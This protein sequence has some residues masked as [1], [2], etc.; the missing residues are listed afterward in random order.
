MPEEN[1]IMIARPPPITQPGNSSSV[2][3]EDSNAAETLWE[4]GNFVIGRRAGRREQTNAFPCDRPYA[5]HARLDG[6]PSGIGIDMES[7]QIR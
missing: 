3:L 4:Y 7:S 1:Q 6:T 5:K 2:P